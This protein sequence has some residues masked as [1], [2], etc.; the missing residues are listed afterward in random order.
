MRFWPRRK[1]DEG[2]LPYRPLS[3]EAFTRCVESGWQIAQEWDSKRQIVR[4][5]W[6]WNEDTF[7]HA[8]LLEAV[9][10][11]ALTELNDEARK[12]LLARISV[13]QYGPDRRPSRAQ[14]HRWRRVGI[15][16]KEN[17]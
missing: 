14:R 4:G 3:A 8:L 17:G 10:E 6:S 7:K 16:G 1:K 5:R 9:G 15:E 2:D 13:D 11:E 12:R